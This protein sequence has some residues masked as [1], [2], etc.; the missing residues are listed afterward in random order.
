MLVTSNTFFLEHTPNLILE[1]SLGSLYFCPDILE[2]LIRTK[3]TFLVKDRILCNIS[4][5]PVSVN[6]ISLILMLI[7]T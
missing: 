1:I 4:S 7:S 6:A 5:L 2:T 3:L